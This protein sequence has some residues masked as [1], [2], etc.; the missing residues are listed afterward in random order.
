MADN[1]L[2]SQGSAQ[3]QGAS[4]GQVAL[5]EPAPSRRSER[6]A[7]T[8][9]KTVRT[10]SLPGMLVD[11]GMLSGDHVGKARE[12]ALRERTALW[13]VLVR[14]G[15]VLSRDLVAMVAMHLGLSMVNLRNR[16]IDR[17]AVTTVSEDV[18]RKYTILPI[19]REAE[20]LIVAMVD[21]TDLRVLQ[22]LMAL[23]GRRIEPVLATPEDIIEH[24]EI[25]F[26][27]MEHMGDDADQDGVYAIGQITTTDIRTA[28]PV[29][30]INILLAQALQDRSSDIHIEPT[31]TYLRVRFRIDGILH[32][33]MKLSLEVHPAVISRLKVMSGMNIAERRRPQDGQVTAE[34]QGRKVDV[35]VAVSSTVT[36]E[37]AV[38]RLLD[39]KFTLFGMDQLGM[40]AHDLERFRKLL[41][42]PHGMIIVCGPTGSGKSTSL[43]AACLNMDRVESNVITLEDPVEYHIPDTDQM[44]IHNEAG[45]TFA[46]QLRSILRLDPDVILVGEIRDEETAV[47]ATQAALTGHLV[48]TSLHANDS[49][50]ALVRLKDLGVPGYL[51]SS[52]VAGIIAQ[53]MVRV[54]C[55]GRKALS[56][57]PHPRA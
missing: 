6:P 27:L 32:D 56:T 42:L 30:V 21:P 4:P 51:I 20:V 16:P 38:L 29:D 54:V 25:S 10:L 55:T 35:R 47:I 14:D 2:I 28:A 36:G 17:K 43:Y 34:I 40:D 15:Y 41:T 33:V 5:R 18:A 3:G 53:R 8:F 52:S 9:S 37:M 12:S 49:L 11:S 1:D 48:L 7:V 13:K 57:R 44:Q 39:K 50:S 31:E 24:I 26:R 23:T 45:I 46:T 22:D 19:E